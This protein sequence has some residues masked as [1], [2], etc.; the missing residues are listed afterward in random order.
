[1]DALLL[2][3]GEG[4]ASW[5]GDSGSEDAGAGLE[6]PLLVPPMKKCGSLPASLSASSSISISL[7]LT[8]TRLYPTSSTS[9]YS[10]TSVPQG[11]GRLG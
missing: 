4:V 5:S 11:V 2:S 6:S 1:M 9:S 7:L 10:S 3:G 8:G